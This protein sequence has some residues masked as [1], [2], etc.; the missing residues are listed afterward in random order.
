MRR[1]AIALSVALALAGSAVG[2]ALSR[3]PLVVIGTN[4]I[5]SSAIVEFEKGDVGNCQR[6]G[7]VPAGTSAI[8]VALEAR[9]VGP[10]VALNIAAGTHV[11]TEGARAAGWGIAPDVTVPV[12]VVPYTMQD[13]LMCIA[14]G[15]TIEPFRVRG[16]PD[17]KLAT[18]VK[19][20]DQIGLHM[21]YLRSSGES[22]WDRAS[23]VARHMGLGHATP[24]T[25]LVFLALALALMLAVCALAVR[26][27]LRESP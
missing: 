6:S 13:P 18:E 2:V 7:T 23:S 27:V 17:D 10:R 11:V 4:S 8:R 14:I 1:V 5:P 9:A 15:P 24:G 12:N 16:E 26:L 22:W 3:S 19:R 25:W 20:L 21:E